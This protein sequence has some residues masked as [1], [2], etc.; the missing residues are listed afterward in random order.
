MNK[1]T[2]EKI[3]E[4][5]ISWGDLQQMMQRAF[6]EGAANESRA[7]VNKGFSKALSFNILWDS[8]KGEPPLVGVP[9]GVSGW[10]GRNCL[11]EF[12][13]YWNGWRPAKK[14]RD[15]PP[16]AHEEALTP[17]LATDDDVLF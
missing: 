7:I 15:W 2:A 4:R 12:G 3:I 16:P 6:D 9:I 10:H 11:R 5:G 1:T 14:Q 8:I 13:A 17:V